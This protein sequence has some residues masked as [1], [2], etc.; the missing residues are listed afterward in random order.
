ME[1]K[2]KEEIKDRYR[3]YLPG[4]ILVNHNRR[5]NKG[6][7]DFSLDGKTALAIYQ[8]LSNGRIY[9]SHGPEDHVQGGLDLYWRPAD[10]PLFGMKSCCKFG[11]EKFGYGGTDFKILNSKTASQ[12]H[13]IDC[14]CS[15]CGSEWR[16]DQRNPPAKW[17]KIL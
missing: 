12:Q 15:S 5:D 10:D 2:I 14:R 6:S 13:W 3:K 7:V 4:Y 1:E 16:Y 8:V 9:I 11:M 17:V